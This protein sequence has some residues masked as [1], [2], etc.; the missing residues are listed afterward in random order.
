MNPGLSAPAG[1]IKVTLPEF[2]VTG[3]PRLFVTVKVT[4]TPIEWIIVYSTKRMEYL[5]VALKSDA[6][7]NTEHVFETKAQVFEVTIV[8][9]KG[10]V[11]SEV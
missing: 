3:D 4:K 10:F 2:K 5:E 7:N 9:S 8:D 1:E 11:K 6:L